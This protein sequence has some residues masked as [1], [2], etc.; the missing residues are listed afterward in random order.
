MP[1]T[2]R[3]LVECNN[4]NAL[5]VHI[6][7]RRTSR[8][9]LAPNDEKERKKGGKKKK[10]HDER[11]TPSSRTSQERSK[12][13]GTWQRRRESARTDR[14]RIEQ[15]R[16]RER[17][18]IGAEV[19]EEKGSRDHNSHFLSFSLLI[20][21]STPSSGLFSSPPAVIPSL[22][23]RDRNRTKRKRTRGR[24]INE[25]MTNTEYRKRKLT[26]R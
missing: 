15:E 16:E 5:G 18:Q 20:L 6:S 21:L 1:G 23:F 12:E 24:V 2:K 8:R 11:T 7:I 25:G 9:H 22:I 10:E 14:R 17:A 3:P 26:R 13:N 19:F 4:L